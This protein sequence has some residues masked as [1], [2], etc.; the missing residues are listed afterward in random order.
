MYYI[1]YLVFPRMLSSS[2][3]W[4]IKIPDMGEKKNTNV[5]KHSLETVI[6]T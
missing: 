1:K 3:N 4:S 6:A 5:S 2:L